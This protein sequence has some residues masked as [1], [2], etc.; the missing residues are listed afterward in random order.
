MW[1]T[2][3]TLAASLEV[4]MCVLSFSGMQRYLV[5]IKNSY[6]LRDVS[7]SVLI[8]INGILSIFSQMNI[9]QSKR[10]L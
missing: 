5:F 7:V 4:K 8:G 9:F 10:S 1:F 2:E 3:T 6:M